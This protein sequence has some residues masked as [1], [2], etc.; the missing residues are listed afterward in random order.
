MVASPDELRP[1]NGTVPAEEATRRERVRERHS[2]IVTYAT[3]AAVAQACSRS[4]E[5][6]SPPT[7]RGPGCGACL[8]IIRWST[9]TWT[10]R[11][12]GSRT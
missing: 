5:A 6:S 9:L 1:P 2:G 10:R 12:G 8:S 3:D 7:W 11:E 4:T